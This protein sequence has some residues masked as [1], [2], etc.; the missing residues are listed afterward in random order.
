MPVI[1]DTPPP[2]VANDLKALRAHLDQNIPAKK[3]ND[4]LLIATWNLRAFASLTREWTA[5]ANASPKRD[6]R[7]LQAIGEI[8]RRFDVIAIQD[9]ERKSACPAGP[10]AL[11]GR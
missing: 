11:A 6:L 2:A 3:A 5:R 7:A 4:N 8:V 1:T 10:A 9:G